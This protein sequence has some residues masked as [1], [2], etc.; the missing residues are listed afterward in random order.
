MTYIDV[1]CSCLGGK[2]PS[3]RR[4]LEILR[5]KVRQPHPL[6]RKNSINSSFSTVSTLTSKMGQYFGQISS[7]CMID[8][9]LLSLP[10]NNVLEEKYLVAFEKTYLAM[11]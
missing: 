1:I 4:D 5:S 6:Y 8:S 10:H 3:D 11:P 2:Q 9:M 7:P